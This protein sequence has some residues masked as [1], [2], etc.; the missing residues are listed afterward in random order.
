MNIENLRILC[1]D[2]TIVITDHTVRRIVKRS[3]NYDDIKQV[4][5]NG[6]II[7]QYPNDYPF[8]SCLILGIASDDRPLHLV[9]GL[10]DGK[11]WI[12]TAYYPSLDKWE[13]DFK[14]RKAVETK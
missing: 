2:E 4:I 12:I 13:N 9:V 6:E 5:L 7:E 3:I 11:L 14:T 1:T 8:P 10:G